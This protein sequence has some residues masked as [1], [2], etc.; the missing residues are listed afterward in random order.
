MPLP[1][2]VEREEL[3]CR[4]LEMRGY[5]R[6][7]GDYEIEGRVTDVKTHSIQPRGRDTPMPAG[8]PIHDMSVRLVVDEFLVV[9][10]VVA[11]IDGHPF[12]DCAHAAGSLAA[13]KGAR[14]AAGWTSRVKSLLGKESC[15]H[16]VEILI[17]MATAAYQTLAEVR[18]ERG[19][20]VDASGKP[21]RIDSCYAYS[22]ARDLVRGRW[23]AFHKPAGRA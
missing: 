8:V 10:D 4:T 14:I 3:H 1:A 9:K 17:P 2:S 16:L 18:F 23:P 13:L 6:I 7:D 20:E 15:T 12:P 22:D 11:V 21:V 5:R 19:D